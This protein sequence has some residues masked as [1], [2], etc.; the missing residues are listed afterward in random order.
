MQ[1]CARKVLTARP[2]SAPV[3]CECCRVALRVAAAQ[4]DAG[5]AVRQQRV[6]N[7]REGHN[8]RPCELQQPQIPAPAMVSC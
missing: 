3:G 2:P 4:V 6:R 7:G 1:L 8:L 5:Q